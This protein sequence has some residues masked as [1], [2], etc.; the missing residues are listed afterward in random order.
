MNQL[1]GFLA[2]TP[3]Q[4]KTGLHNFQTTYGKTWDGA[5]SCGV[6]RHAAVALHGGCTNR[7]RRM[8]ERSYSFLATVQIFGAGAI[9]C[10]RY[11][12]YI[13][14]IGERALATHHVRKESSGLRHRNCKP[15]DTATAFLDV[16]ALRRLGRHTC[17]NLN[18]QVNMDIKSNFFR[19][20]EWTLFSTFAASPGCKPKTI[21]LHNQALP[22][23]V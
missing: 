23:K 4:N 6:M 12:Q 2:A 18:P 21:S 5:S 8:D 1:M 7:R 17:G 14:L 9:R 13:F 16:T 22:L 10:Q 3:L 20:T 15:H 11:L 19:S